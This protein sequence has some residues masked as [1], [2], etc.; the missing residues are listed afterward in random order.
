[1][2]FAH[3][4][5]VYM[6]VPERL[7][8]YVMDNAWQ[9]RLSMLGRVIVTMH[10]LRRALAGMVIVTMHALRGALAGRVIV[11]ERVMWQQ[12]SCG[13]PTP[14]NEGPNVMVAT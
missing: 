12:P 13:G 9:G 1:M 11:A 7:R 10:A 6:Y 14:R 4:D 3:I 5:D 2:S 8:M